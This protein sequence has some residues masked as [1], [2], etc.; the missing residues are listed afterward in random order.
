MKK[1]LSGISL[2]ALAFMLQGCDDPPPKEPQIIGNVYKTVQECAY[3]MP[4]ATCVTA[5][6]KAIA[7][8]IQTSE[9]FTDIDSCM[10]KY[11]Q[12][13]CANIETPE[14]ETQDQHPGDR[15]IPKFQGFSVIVDYVPE[16][17]E[18]GDETGNTVPVYGYT[19]YVYQ[20]NFIFV[21]NYHP[22][23][24]SSGFGYSKSST[25]SI[26]TTRINNK[27]VA[28]TGTRVNSS[29]VRPN[30]TDVKASISRSGFGTRSFSASRSMVSVSRGG[31]GGRASGFG[32]GRGG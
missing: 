14:V 13:G 9:K 28:S 26:F 8:T 27:L 25:T 23:V 30:V 18:D 21:G 7:E 4:Y 32:G 1:M 31:F 3:D 6:D 11:G 2:I 24:V 29:Y 17:D 5:H 20:P 12:D 10:D 19:G 16:E 22:Y 15:F